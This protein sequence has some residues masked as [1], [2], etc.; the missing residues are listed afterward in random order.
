MKKMF[1]IFCALVLT[2]AFP[3]LAAPTTDFSSPIEIPVTATYQE[4][5]NTDTVYSVDIIWGS[6][7]FT[8]QVQNGSWDPKTH[9]YSTSSSGTWANPV[10]GDNNLKSNQLKITNHSNA[11]VAFSIEYTPND[12]YSNISALFSFDGSKGDPSITDYSLPTAVKKTQTD[13]SLTKTFDLS[14]IGPL[15]ETASSTPIGTITI[16]LSEV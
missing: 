12:S 15:P 11:A 16:T 14:L 13:P 2:L 10:T 1:V 3:V 5:A 9:S 4:I 7:D 8:Y 6:M